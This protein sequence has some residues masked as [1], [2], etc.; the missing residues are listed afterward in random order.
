MIVFITVRF[1]DIPNLNKNGWDKKHNNIKWDKKRL[2]WYYL[3]LNCFC[4][5][6]TNTSLVY[7]YKT[8]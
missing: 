2:N 1:F 6:S 8:P 4:F 5:K 7:N 3:K